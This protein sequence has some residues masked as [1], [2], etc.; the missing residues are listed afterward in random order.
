MYPNGLRV[1]R[2]ISPDLLQAIRDAGYSY[3]TRRWERHDGTDIMSAEE[4][5]LSG[6]QRELDSIGIRRSSLQKVLYRHALVLGI[7]IT[8]QK[9]LAGA[10]ERDDGL[11]EVVFQDGTSRMTQVLFGADGALGKSRSI[12]AGENEPRLKY[13]GVT[14]LM[15]LSSCRRDGIAFPSSDQ[16]DFHAVFFPTAENEQCFQFHEPIPEKEADSLNWGNLSHEVSK[17]ECRRIACKL[18]KEGWHEKYVQPLENVIQAVRVGFALLEPNLKSW[19]KGRVALVGDA[20]HPPVPY[21]G[22]F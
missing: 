2:D 4:S 18:R 17:L 6:D 12:V 7:P 5:I 22:K 14:C 20:A 13:T 11:L 16:D 21:I 19:V 9:P 15:G 1:I 8:F 3:K 10:V